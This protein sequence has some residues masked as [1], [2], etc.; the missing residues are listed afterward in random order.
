M[1]LLTKVATIFDR[2]VDL[3]SNLASI[4]LIFMMLAVGADVVMR[5]FFSRPMVWLNEVVG[6]LLLYFT[7]LVATWVL[8]RE[9]H[10]RMDLVVRRLSPRVQTILDIIA[11][12]LGVIISLV[13][14]WFGAQ[15]TLE[16][17]QKG[18]YIPTQ[19]D[20][21]N[22]YILVI[23]PI[24]SFLLFVQFLRRTY[25]CLKSQGSSPDKE[26]RA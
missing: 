7:F 10:V 5:Y 22:A 8:R 26:R 20:I 18:L 11:S 3:L 2:T 13:L 6:A 17:W 9:G 25:R 23:I 4:I 21:P 19:L 1:K 24:G 12:I 14:M 15:V 16:H